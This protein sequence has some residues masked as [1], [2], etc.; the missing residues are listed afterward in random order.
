MQ[1]HSLTI[2]NFRV[3]KQSDLTFQDKIIGLVG[4]NGAGKSTI[5][6]AVAWALYGNQAS[7]TGKE[8]IRS[9][10]AGRDE[11]C[12]V[13]LD[14]SVSGQRYRVSRRIVGR[15]ERNE[16]EL[17]RG[18][19]AHAV[20]V[21]EAKESIGQLLGLDWKGFCTSF[22][23]RQQELNAL[24]DLPPAKRK[25]YLAG[26]LGVERLDK[27]IQRAKTDARVATGQADVLERQIAERGQIEVRIEQLT[28]RVAK[29]TADFKSTIGGEQDQLRAMQEAKKKWDMLESIK[30]RATQIG[31]E[32][33]TK[34]QRLESLRQNLRELE[35]EQKRLLGL[36]RELDSLAAQLK[37]RDVVQSGYKRMQ[38]SAEKVELHK[39]LL[40][41]HGLLSGQLNEGAEK[42]AAL[43]RQLEE[44]E[45]LL[46][47]IGA[48]SE[49]QIAAARAELESARAEYSR[50]LAEQSRVTND[51]ARL[52][53]QLDE[54]SRFG[55][56]SVCDRCGR[57]LGDDLSTIRQ[58]FQAEISELTKQG[59]MLANS[60]TSLKD[61]GEKR[62]QL[63]TELEGRR[64]KGY[65][66]SVLQK[67]L[68]TEKATVSDQGS[69]LAKQFNQVKLQIA[70][71]A[72]I[73][74]GFDAAE[75]ADLSARVE[76]LD[77]V[78]G[79]SDDLRGA[80]GTTLRVRDSIEQSNKEAGQC[81][82]SVKEL[83]GQLSELGFDPA[84]C[85][86]RRQA[87]DKAQTELAAV[88]E[89]RLLKEKER[90]VV[91]TEL[92][93]Q[94]DRRREYE[95][96]GKQLEEYRDSA[97]YVTKLSGLMS[98]YRSNIIVSI[99][100]RLA[101]LSSA[102][103]SDMTDSRYTLVELDE[104]YNLRLLDNGSFYGVERFSGGEKDLAN[105]CL[106]LAISQALTESVGLDRSFV[107]LDEIF[108][109]QDTERQ[110]LIIG[111]LAHLRH[112][113]PQIVLVTHIEDLKDRVE[114]LIEISPTGRGYSE[115]R[116]SE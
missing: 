111:A 70:S 81:V 3:V 100:P 114:Q 93:G 88:R 43:D 19:S 20:G 1:L 110:S 48:V 10:F 95:K 21:T 2:R 104:K 109:S 38:K 32:L 41:Q 18:E 75:Y 33:S 87:F 46:E 108:G 42:V 76:R 37:E 78:K 4:P 30:D 65:E 17:F 29:L 15:S 91:Q 57:R 6:E 58:H 26:M 8:E 102:L 77:K 92:S 83:E 22:L 52:T 13:T 89:S 55:P 73:A 97:Y 44:S 84:E 23:A 99:R 25:D 24:S 35:A 14:F 54:I 28:T 72:E 90:E 94:L 12:E 60:L 96:I 116:S 47:Q 112:R 103:I 79:R 115:I 53:K 71:I 113:F 11:S 50:L 51:V 49:E 105:L 80:L 101:E 107:I 66:Q 68:R 64:K 16:V 39:Q 59:E 62:G 85:E 36:Q 67:S 98:E 106:R 61:Q 56:E 9:T 31:N 86:R 82:A 40:E 27:A 7:R 34:R 45:Q 74:D 5:I 69:R 63:V